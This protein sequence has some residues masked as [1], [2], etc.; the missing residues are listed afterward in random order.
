MARCSDGDGET[1][2]SLLFTSV[3]IKRFKAIRQNG[4]GQIAELDRHRVRD[5]LR[6][7]TKIH[8][9]RKT[10]L[11]CG[12]SGTLPPA[13]TT[14]GP[15]LVY[16][17]FGFRSVDILHKCEITGSE[18]CEVW[19]CLNSFLFF[20]FFF[21]PKGQARGS[22]PSFK[23]PPPRHEAKQ[24]ENILTL[25]EIRQDEAR[26]YWK[27]PKQVWSCRARKA[28]LI[29]T[30]KSTEWLTRLK[31]SLFKEPQSNFLPCFSVK[32]RLTMTSST[33]RTWR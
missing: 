3:L 19:A 32:D 8:C 21:L 13:L 2:Q 28:T 16:H 10:F 1:R 18:I 30:T 23:K 29:K 4:R 31:N 33:A 12:D 15:V 17:F 7:P 5:G 6:T 14:T 9:W 20:F 11:C 25:T 27:D 26:A 24:T 22:S